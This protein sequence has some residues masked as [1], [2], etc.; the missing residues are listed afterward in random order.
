ME[1][2]QDGGSK[3][4]RSGEGI[5]EA[6]IEQAFQ[7]ALLVYPPGRKK[8]FIE[9]DCC[10]YGRNEAISRFIK[11]QTGKVRT[12]KQI[13]NHIVV[14]QKQKYSARERQGEEFGWKADIQSAFMEA[15]EIYP[16]RKNFTNTEDKNKVFERSYLI[17]KYINGKVLT[18]R[19]ISNHISSNNSNKHNSSNIFN[20][21]NNGTQVTRVTEVTDITAVTLVPQ[22]T[23]IIR[24]I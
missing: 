3:S 23:Q 9:G 14:I 24:I 2:S 8:I 12:T 6:D 18:T 13:S 21:C 19:Q 7:K 17:A 11:L 4:F 1:Q 15:V 5:W 20:K 22:V 10:W 16:H